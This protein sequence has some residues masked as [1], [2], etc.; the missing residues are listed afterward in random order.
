MT[1]NEEDYLEHHGILGMRWG[2]R[3]LEA[4]TKLQIKTKGISVKGDGSINVDKGVSLQRLVRG[5]GSSIPL[6]DITYASLTD[7]DNA[8]YIKY[9]GGKGFFG[10]GRDKVLQLT[11]RQPIKAP[12]VDEA[13]KIVVGIF[14]TDKKFRETFKPF[15]GEAI[16]A[17]ELAEIVANPTGKKAKLWYTAVNTSLTFDS[18]FDPTAPYIQKTVRE[19]FQKKGFNA[20]RDE[21]D[22][23]SGVSKAPIIIFSP[24]TTVKVTTVSD[25]TDDMRNMSKDKLKAY[26]TLGR[27]WVQ[28][29]LYD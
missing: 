18:E 25:I 6:K 20:V 21:N 7:Y 24:E 12:S 10:G 16:S 29:E 8:K 22:F 23:Q 3:K 5:D 4:K 13:S 2:H 14:A 28:K 19:T 15:M 1:V 26:S 27:D 17:H 11:T 9:I